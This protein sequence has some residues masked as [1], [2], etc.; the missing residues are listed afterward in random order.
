MSRAVLLAPGMRR[1]LTDRLPARLRAD[2]DPHVHRAGGPRLRCSRRQPPRRSS[3][4]SRSRRW[5]RASSSD[6]SPIGTAAS[7]GAATLRDIAPARERGCASSSGSRADRGSRCSCPRSRSSP[8]ARSA[9]T[10]C[11]TRSQASSSAPSVPARRSGLAATVLFG[12]GA[13]GA[14]LLGFLA[15]AARL[16]RAL[17]GGRRRWRCAGALLVARSPARR[18]RSYPDAARAT[19][20]PR[21][22]TS[23]SSRSTRSPSAGAASRGTTASSSSSRAGC[24]ATACAR[25][26]SRSS[27]A[28]A[29]RCASRR[30]RSA[31]TTSRRRARTSACCGGC[32][33]QDLAYERQL[34]HKQAQIGDALQRIGG[35][36][37]LRDARDRARRPAARLP[38][39][40]RVHLDAHTGR[41]RARA[42]TRPGAGTRCSRSRPACSQARTA[43]R[44][45]RRSATGRAPRAS[46]PTSSRTAL[47]YLR[48]LVVREGIRTGEVLCILVTSP[49]EYP[50][51]DA[52]EQLLA[53]RCP[54]RRRR[55]AR[56]QRGHR[57]ARPQGLRGAR[58]LRPR[59]VRG[60]A[61]RS[62]PARLRRARS[63]RRTPR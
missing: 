31:P 38:Q 37:R 29:R 53:E 36:D 24:R 49:G 4:P 63:C 8:S 62:A 39:Q 51:F 13:I 58:G 55:A 23:S 18:R 52:L 33:W 2:R 50:D 16:P 43:A 44:C 34:E 48:H 1:L 14:I 54:T 25:A 40:A 57:R 56:D 59:L 45:A 15:D 26:S 10:A 30:S 17:A 60:G 32:R 41:A 3:R 12:G 27:S 22:A 11:S 46:T 9:S 20:L 47:G 7:G 21:Q 35:L 61:A 5:R 28:T 42:S 19:P 6:A